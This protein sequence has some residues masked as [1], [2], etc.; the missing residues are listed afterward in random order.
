MGWSRR[1]GNCHCT[2]KT[3]I[4]LEERNNSIP[5]QTS[6]FNVIKCGQYCLGFVSDVCKHALIL[7]VNFNCYSS[8]HFK[9]I[10]VIIIIIIIIINLDCSC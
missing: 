10:I 1:D 8:I 3:P 9:F 6:Y 4:N 7:A 2:V 5:C